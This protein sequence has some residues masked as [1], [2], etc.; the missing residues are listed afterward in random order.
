MPSVRKPASGIKKV[1]SSRVTTLKPVLQGKSGKYQ[2]FYDRKGNS[3]EV[4]VIA[5][6][7]KA[8]L[9]E[10]TSRLGTPVGSAMI[11]SK[12]IVR[13]GGM[14]KGRCAI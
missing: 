13:L 14:A 3:G 1:V 12:G 10:V 7:D 11:D 8:A 5:S 4:L 9:S 6:A 2:V